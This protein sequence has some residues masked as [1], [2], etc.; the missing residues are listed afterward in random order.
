MH[1]AYYDLIAEVDAL[2]LRR[3]FAYC[4]SAIACRVDR[5]SCVFQYLGVVKS[6]TARGPFPVRTACEW[7]LI[8]APDA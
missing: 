1:P 8:K 3:S 5:D 4:L 6:S 7:E 2:E